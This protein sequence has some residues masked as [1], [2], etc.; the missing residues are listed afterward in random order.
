M[1]C[2]EV[3]FPPPLPA[4]W[5]PRDYEATDLKPTRV[6]SNDLACIISRHCTI[7]EGGEGSADNDVMNGAAIH[8]VKIGIVEDAD[9]LRMLLL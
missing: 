8:C 2:G 7:K 9:H 5:P 1:V 6:A 3:S 4:R